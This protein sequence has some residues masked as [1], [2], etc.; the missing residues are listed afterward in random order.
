[1][2]KVAL[3]H[4]QVFNLLL[5]HHQKWSDKFHFT[6]R[7]TNRYKRLDMGYWFH[8]NDEYIAVSFW[9]GFDYANRTPNISFIIDPAD[10][11]TRLELSATDS[12]IKYDFLVEKVINTIG[13]FEHNKKRKHTKKYGYNDCIESLRQFLK[14]DKATIDI[15]IRENRSFFKSQSEIHRIEFIK[16]SEFNYSLR[17]TK[18]RREEFKVNLPK[19]LPVALKSIKINDFGPIKGREI[20]SLDQF[21]QFIFLTGENGS[22]KTSLLRAIALAMNND[23][24]RMLYSDNNFFGD[25]GHYDVEIEIFSKKRIKRNQV[26]AKS[27]NLKAEL[28]YNG[29]VSYGPHRL[30]TTESEY[31]T[32]QKKSD[33]NYS[34]FYDDGV[35]FDLW[36]KIGEWNISGRSQ[37]IK[38]R[39]DSIKTTLHALN[40]KL[41]AIL[42]PGEDDNEGPTLYQETDNDGNYFDP[43]EFRKLA[44]GTRSII[45]MFGDMIMRLFEQQPKVEDVADFNGIVIIDEIDI[46]LHPNLQKLLIEQL[47]ATFPYIQFI[48]STHS[49][50]PILGGGPGSKIYKIERSLEDG[51]NIIEIEIDNV[52]SLNPNIILTSPIFG[53]SDIISKNLPNTMDLRTEDSWDDMLHNDQLDKELIALY[54]KKKHK[55]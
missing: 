38:K 26:N 35:L 24:R 46:H 51:V 27:S 41:G 52:I 22:G 33:T 5:D 39:V 19:E 44:S 3:I 43:V 18:K 23:H 4:E 28:L 13:D 47:Q 17:R 37:I 34:L 40:N 14:Q 7:K 25:T 50:I 12:K 6:L 48:V 45:A 21:C 29:F 20:S 31:N 8:G 53:M 10:E 9:T 49:P 16:T 42:F 32:D 11:S 36:D 15:I 1:M 2:N 54:K 30:V 55:K